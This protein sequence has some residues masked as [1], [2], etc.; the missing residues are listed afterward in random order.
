MTTFRLTENQIAQYHRDGYV[1]V[2]RLFDAEETE[3]L[4]KISRANQA[5]KTAPEMKDAQGG[6]SKISL[7]FNPPAAARSGLLRKSNFL[8]VQFIRFPR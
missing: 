2:P 1:F 3:L 5:F 7:R 6:G 8:P 4:L